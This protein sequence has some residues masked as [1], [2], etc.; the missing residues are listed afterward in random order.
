MERAS[1]ARPTLS[2]S[3]TDP[4]DDGIPGVISLHVW[5]AVCSARRAAGPRSLGY[6]R[7]AL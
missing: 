4:G 7:I 6:I 5:E 1:L 2:A 3:Q